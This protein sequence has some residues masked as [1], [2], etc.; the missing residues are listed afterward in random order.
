M[1]GEEGQGDAALGALLENAPLGL[2]VWDAQLRCVQAN[3]VLCD[4]LGVPESQM[5]G[6]P[7]SEVFPDFAYIEALLQRV[8]DD[9]RPLRD[10]RV[11]GAI[12]QAGTHKAF[13][14]SYY[15]LTEAGEQRAGGVLGIAVEL[16]PTTEAV[17]SGQ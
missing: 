8:L 3:A 15:P 10:L 9:G 2:A 17:A 14:V 11:A 12:D 6:K 5:L 4:V 7:V 1:Q 16:D 13:S